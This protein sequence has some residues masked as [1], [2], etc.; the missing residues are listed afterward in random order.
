MSQLASERLQSSTLRFDFEDDEITGVLAR[1]DGDSVTSIG[2]AVH[3]SIIELRR[4]F[5]PELVKT[6]EDL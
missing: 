5:I 3:P 2:Q 1:P 4:Q 6:M